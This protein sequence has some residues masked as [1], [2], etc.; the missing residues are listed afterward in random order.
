M[1][2]ST[3]GFEITEVRWVGRASLRVTVATAFTG[4]YFQLYAGRQ[5]IGVSSIAGEDFV[6]GQLFR[7]HCPHCLTVVMCEEGEQLTD[8]GSQLARRPFNQFQ[9][10]WNA[11]S[12]PADAKWFELTA[13]TAAG[14]SVDT[15]NVIAR[16]AYIG[17]GDY[18]FLF[19]PVTEPGE[20]EYRITPLDDAIPSGNAGTPTDVTLS[21]IPYP[22]DVLMNDENTRLDVSIAEGVLTVDFEYDWEP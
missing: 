5:L 18:R 22:P 8:Y 6:I 16:V 17:D 9:M 3:G 21:T 1:T 10:A 11:D 7:A 2:V 12:F 14:E 4:R 19:P 13:A 20:W 15:E